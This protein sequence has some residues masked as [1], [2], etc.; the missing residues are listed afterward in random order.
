MLLITA[1]AISFKKQDMVFIRFINN[2]LICTLR[3]A[4]NAISKVYTF[5][6]LHLQLTLVL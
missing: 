3:E 5:K 4:N 2:I 6:V 1:I